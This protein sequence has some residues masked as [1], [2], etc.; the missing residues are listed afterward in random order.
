MSTKKGEAVAEEPKTEKTIGIKEFFE[1]IP[2]S[3]SVRVS[4][5]PTECKG[6][7]PPIWILSSG[8]D[9]NSERSHYD[10]RLMRCCCQPV[11]R[12]NSDLL[13]NQ[14]DALSEE[15][16]DTKGFTSVR[17]LRCRRWFT[18]PQFPAPVVG[19]DQ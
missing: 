14:A 4:G 1:K 7:P 15:S 6:P 10:A 13:S 9:G 5:I 12:L 16:S 3:V 18:K 2:P 11:A 17:N 8:Q 19:T